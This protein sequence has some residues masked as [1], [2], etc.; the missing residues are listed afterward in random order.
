MFI[1]AARQFLLV[2]GLGFIVAGL[3]TYV[4]SWILTSVH[5]RDKHPEER[6]KLGGFLFAPHALGW[7]LALRYR[8]IDDSGLHAL[9]R[10]ASIGVWTIIIGGVA[11]LLSVVLGKF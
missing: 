9:A 5:L 11:A 3:T 6:A 10:L 1:L 7:F 8:R 4:I 2:M